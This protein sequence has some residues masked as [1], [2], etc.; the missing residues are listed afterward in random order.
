M[1]YQFALSR[2][3]LPGNDDSGGISS[4]FVWNAIGL[5]PVT[6]QSIMM[7]GSPLFDQVGIKRSDG[8]FVIQISNNSHENIYLKSAS[9]NG[10][11]LKYPWFD[12]KSLSGDVGLKMEMDK[13]GAI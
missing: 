4:W 9:V 13:R 8:E 6:G 2:G 3:G 7:L 10:I 12:L 11:K 5:F 1:K